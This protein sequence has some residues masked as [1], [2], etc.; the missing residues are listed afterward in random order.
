MIRVARVLMVST[1]LVIGCAQ[2]NRPAA[3][4][5]ALDDA[6]GIVCTSTVAQCISDGGGICEIKKA[7]FTLD[8][9]G[10]GT[11]SAI[12]SSGPLTGTWTQSGDTL[13][14]TNLDLSTTTLTVSHG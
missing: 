9:N 3:T 13:V 11:F 14:L 7:S 8:L 4:C 6:T 1:L 10:D 2:D 5:S 12:T